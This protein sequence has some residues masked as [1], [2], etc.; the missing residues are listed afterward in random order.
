MY[1]KT[2]KST[3]T[4]HVVTLTAALVT[5]MTA[6]GQT[7]ENNFT[8]EEI[9]VTAQKREESLSDVPISITALGGETLARAGLDSVSD[10][11]TKVPGLRI[12][13][14]GGFSQPTIRNI[15]SSIAGTGFS[16]NVAT[17]VDG[18]YSA[19]QATIDMKM[20]DLASVQVLKGPQG[21][22]FGRNATGGAILLSTLEPGDETELNITARAASYNKFSQNLYGSM[23]LTDSLAANIS[24]LHESGD[25]YV[26]NVATGADDDGAFTISAMRTT[27]LF[28]P[29]EDSSYKLSLYRSKVKDPTTVTTGSFEALSAGS[30]IATVLPPGSVVVAD[31]PYEVS[32]TSP[33]AFSSDSQGAQFT[34]EFNFDSFDL[35]SYTMVRDEESNS[36][37][38]LDG[39]SI[40]I[41]DVTFDI[42]NDAWS[43]EFN[44]SGNTD[45]VD[46][47]VGL[48]YLT[49]N[50]EYADFS[51]SASGSALATLYNLGSEIET[52]AAF[53][54]VTY[55]LSES[56]F[57]TG[58]LR[59]SYE[60]AEGFYN[61]TPV[62]TAFLGV[63]T[64]SVPVDGD[65][66]AVTPRVVVR[67]QPNDDFNYYA[68]YT[69]GFRAGLITP[70]SFTTETIDQESVDAFEIGMKWTT[71]NDMRLDAAIFYY[72]YQDM[73]LASYDGV[74]AIVENAGESTIYGAELALATVI[75][76]N[77]QFSIGMS[78]TDGEYDK[79]DDAPIFIQ[80]TNPLSPTFST[81]PA[82][83]IDAAGFEMQRSPKFT[84]NV[85]LD[86]SDHI[87]IGTLN[88]SANYYYSSSFYFDPA[89]Q[90]EQDAYGLL[91]LSVGL[92][93]MEDRLSIR[94]YGKNVLD[95]EYRTQVLPGSFAVQETWGEPATVGIELG[96]RL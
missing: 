12:D 70:S 84:G 40:P 26:D 65:W 54:D 25:G 68:S 58:G 50:E 48:Y 29:T 59:Y 45:K 35:V 33:T 22:L 52:F 16:S 21:T 7:S 93:T 85:G 60:E 80:D 3:P 73:Q 8:L 18:F 89:N 10:L 92:E 51:A 27:W 2:F 67:Y 61:V 41:F 34:A 69:Q 55:Q 47:L 28:T 43:Q 79:F 15:G 94:L 13:Q 95:E 91:N 4:S 53:A 96:Y 5:P 62:C 46:W 31:Q 23:R 76:N 66:D 38:D 19:S 78:Y 74:S 37:L 81:F 49:V 56:W 44:F 77:L 39:A 17:Y 64:G 72:D 36:Q 86:F 9:V 57:L 75:T 87:G 11:P 32:N 30:A 82:S 20:A 83:S 88:M 42:E 71:E 63:P 14:A 24:L 6:I 1:K 90:F